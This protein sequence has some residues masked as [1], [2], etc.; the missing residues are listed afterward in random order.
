MKTVWFVDD[1]VEMSH[2]I[3]LI[4]GLLGFNM[5]AFK[6]ARSAVRALKQGDRPDVL[7]LDISMPEVTGVDLLEYIRKRMG[8][9]DLPILM[10]SSEATDAQVDQAIELGADGFVAKPVT[11]DELEAAIEKVLKTNGAYGLASRPK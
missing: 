4:L 7:I 9:N 11:I 6:D 5:L 10:L 3:S 2:A 8:V 1:D